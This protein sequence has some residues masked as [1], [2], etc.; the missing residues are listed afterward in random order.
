MEEHAILTLP[1]PTVCAP[2][3]TEELTARREVNSSQLLR[4]AH[5]THTHSR[6]C[7]THMR[8]S[9]FLTQFIA[10]FQSK[11]WYHH[12]MRG[13]HLGHGKVRTLCWLSKMALLAAKVSN[14][15]C[16]MAAYPSH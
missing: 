3:G 11:R 15:F 1:L 16:H 14:P 2:V 9:T 6:K 10:E 8:R 4:I 13:Y 7:H 12:M 5:K